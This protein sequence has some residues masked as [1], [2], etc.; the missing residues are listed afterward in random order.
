MKDSILIKKTNKGYRLTR[1]LSEDISEQD[2]VER[3]K[4]VEGDIEAYT[5]AY[6]NLTT[7]KEELLKQQSEKIDKDAKAFD[8]QLDILKSNLQA[9][10][11]ATVLG[12]GKASTL[13]EGDTNRGVVE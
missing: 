7:N 12:Q 8:R 2:L 5:D 3:I 11:D 6:E 1:T 4:K 13:V 10:K 9:L